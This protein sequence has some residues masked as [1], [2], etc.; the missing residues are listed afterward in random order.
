VSRRKDDKPLCLEEREKIKLMIANG[1]TYNSVARE[2]KRAPKTIKK[3]ATE[4]D[5]AVE[6]SEQRK[7]LAAWYEDMTRR[8]LSSITDEDIKKINAYQ[9][10]VSA[11]I[12][13]DK[14]RLL[15]DQSTENVAVL[16]EAVSDL[17]RRR[18]R[19]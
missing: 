5:M 6:I 10:M 7:D 9:R 15:T 8:M 16:Y 4:P 14:M 1:A 18:R 17:Q 19:G 2:L 11:G 3:C 13:T 12:A